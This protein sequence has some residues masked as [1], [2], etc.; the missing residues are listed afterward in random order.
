MPSASASAMLSLLMQLKFYIFDP[1]YP[2]VFQQMLSPTGVPEQG[3][4]IIDY[5]TLYLAGSAGY[6]KTDT[7][8]FLTCTFLVVN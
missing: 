2:S 4:P 1:H 5:R 8:E 6:D 7:A 3:S